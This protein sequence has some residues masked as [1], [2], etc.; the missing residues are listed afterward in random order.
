MNIKEKYKTELKNKLDYLW[1]DALKT[2]LDSNIYLQAFLIDDKYKTD[3]IVLYTWYAIRERL[4]IGTR[5]LAEPDQKNERLNIESLIK[6]ISKS[7]F[8]EQ[9][10]DKQE[11]KQLCDKFYGVFNS[12]E[13]KRVKNL[14]NVF[15]HNIPKKEQYGCYNKDLMYILQNTLE[16]LIQCYGWLDEEKVDKF[17]LRTLSHDLAVVY[18]NNII[19]AIQPDSYSDKIK[20][21]NKWL[22]E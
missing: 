11:I 3:F 16:I 2:Y 19:N 17:Q 13:M 20:V 12:E 8:C 22:K 7:D 4:V 9:E 10:A 6:F 1:E 15:C 18:W 5:R 21:F 14:R